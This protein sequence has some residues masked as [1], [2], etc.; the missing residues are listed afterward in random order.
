M[1]FFFFFFY[2][3]DHTWIEDQ[4]PTKQKKWI[5]AGKNVVLRAEAI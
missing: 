5:P 3:E 4:N 2:Q 1:R